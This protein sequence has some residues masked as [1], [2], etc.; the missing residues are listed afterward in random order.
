VLFRSVNC[1]QAGTV[2][3]DS[4][5]RFPEREEILAETLRRI[6]GGRLGTPEDIARVV[7]MLCGEDAGWIVGQTIVADGGYDIGM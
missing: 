6:P 7:V 5:K 1:V 3:T 4:L 2:D